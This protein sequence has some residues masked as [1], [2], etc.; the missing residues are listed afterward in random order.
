M[1]ALVLR[2]LVLF[3]RMHIFEDIMPLDD[4]MLKEEL[5]RMF[6]RYLGVESNEVRANPTDS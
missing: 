2:E 6:L 4:D 1:I 5:P 3:N